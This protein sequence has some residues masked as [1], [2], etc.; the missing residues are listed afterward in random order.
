MYLFFLHVST[1]QAVVGC[2][3]R[4]VKTPVVQVIVGGVNIPAW[5]QMWILI[6]KLKCQTN[7]WRH[8]SKVGIVSQIPPNLTDCKIVRH[9]FHQ[10]HCNSWNM[11]S[12]KLCHFIGAL[13]APFFSCN[14]KNI[15]M[16]F[17]K[18]SLSF[19]YT[20]LCF[21]S[22]YHN[23]ATSWGFE[24]IWSLSKARRAHPV[25]QF[26][27]PVRFLHT[28]P[29]SKQGSYKL[30]IPVEGGYKSLLANASELHSPQT[31][32][33]SPPL[34]RETSVSLFNGKLYEWMTAEECAHK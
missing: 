13:M 3:R 2:Q 8:W 28:C 15:C 32:E 29:G 7:W 6:L 17:R 26:L 14:C 1:D 23:I 5:R 24:N 33:V 11:L 4:I 27:K 16:W 18:P 30:T 21:K 10:E 19:N 9:C 20:S 12:F 22:D 31:W 25:F 34:E